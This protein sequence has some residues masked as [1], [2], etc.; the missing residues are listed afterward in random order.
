ML[1][2]LLGKNCRTRTRPLS[3]GR[4]GDHWDRS[5][6]LV[7]DPVLA[8]RVELAE[9]VSRPGLVVVTASS[10]AQAH[11]RLA[12]EAISLVLVDHSL[13]ERAGLEFLTHLRAMHPETRRAL[14]TDLQDLEA[15]QARLE[16][17][18]LAFIVRKPWETSALREQVAKALDRDLP[19]PASGGAG[20][21]SIYPGIDTGLGQDI[22][23]GAVTPSR[24]E[25]LVCGLLAGLNACD[26]SEALMRLVH[27]ELSQSLHLK[28][29]AWLDCGRQRIRALCGEEGVPAPP[30]EES[31]TLPQT[32]R[33]ALEK[34]KTGLSGR[35][36]EIEA[37][38]PR[39]SERTHE[40]VA[41]RFT[42]SHGA[43]LV[44]ALEL[45]RRFSE[46]ALF[47]LARIRSG[48]VMA[49]RRIRQAEIRTEERMRRARRVSSALR[50]PAGSLASEIDRLRAEAERAGLPKEWLDRVASESERVVRAVRAVEVEIE[51]VPPSDTA[52]SF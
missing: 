44:L 35:R 20:P 7:V 10:A 14:V 9:A 18:D 5:R 11:Q 25:L 30:N 26:S 47:V 29:S 1:N 31:E 22:H 52:G 49:L 46:E 27:T 36:F 17:A 41:Y 12:E 6:I 24:R 42:P 32:L 40:V 51:S 15:I 48:L 19:S 37:E 13:G 16:A 50:Q 28:Q 3:S 23:R 4:S 33:T 2:D 34:V 43:P 8:S 21:R 45:P 38:D 39:L